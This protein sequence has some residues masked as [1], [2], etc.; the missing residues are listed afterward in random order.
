MEKK[1][2]GNA[3]LKVIIVILLLALLGAVGYICYDKGIIKLPQ[4][5][6]K[7]VVEKID[8]HDKELSQGE[9]DDISDF[10]KE[11][12]NNFASYYPLSD[13][14]KIDN[15]DLLLF[16]LKRIGFNDLIKETEMEKE[17]KSYFGN[18]EI[19]H[20]DIECP[21]DDEEP[22]YL[23]EEKAYVPN[24]NHFGHGSSLGPQVAV[25]YVSG[26]KDKKDITVNYKILYS[27]SC[28]DT[29]FLDSYYRNYE[30]AVLGNNPVLKGDPD[31]EEG[32]GVNLTEEVYKSVE[33]Q[34]PVTTFKLTKTENGYILKSVDIHE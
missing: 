9:I 25:F 12:S 23:Y 30:D 27:N 15:Q 20:E 17:I 13:F 16:G 6:K 3:G 1:K 29:C 24:P 10:V 34:I 21:T 32:P 2:K 8:K 26:E 31:S 4:K 28:G 14:S 33:V 18:I 5:E 22:L 19:K 7:E 11:V